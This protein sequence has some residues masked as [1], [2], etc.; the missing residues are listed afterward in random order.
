M[1][2]AHSIVDHHKIENQ[3]YMKTQKQ[4]LSD[5]RKALS[6]KQVH[7]R[8]ASAIRGGNELELYPWVDQ[9]GG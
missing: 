9:P 2:T 6:G 7:P 8:E 1:T 3:E 4:K 5:V